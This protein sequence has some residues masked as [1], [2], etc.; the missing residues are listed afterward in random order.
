MKKLISA[1]LCVSGFSFAS[2]IGVDALGQEQIAGGSAAMAGRGFAGTVSRR[3][4]FRCR[5]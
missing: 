3:A 4:L 5:R 2:M 1:L